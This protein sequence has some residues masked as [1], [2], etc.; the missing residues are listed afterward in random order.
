MEEKG[1]RRIKWRRM[2]GKRTK[3]WKNEVKEE[4]R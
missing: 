4:G 2:T 3:E 1:N